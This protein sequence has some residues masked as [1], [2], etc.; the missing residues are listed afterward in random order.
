[1]NLQ[2]AG[3]LAVMAA[4]YIA[5]YTKMLLQ[6]RKGIQTNQIS[7]GNKNLKVLRVEF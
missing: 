6:R 5:Y 7:R 2:Q 3:A 1:M 4:F